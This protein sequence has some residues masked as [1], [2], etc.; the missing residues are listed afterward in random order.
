M[1]PAAGGRAATSS[2]RA[3][4]AESTAAAFAAELP[5][6]QLAVTQVATQNP[7]Q[8]AIVQAA[9]IRELLED[10]H[11]GGL[12]G[13][14]AQLILERCIRS[15]TGWYADADPTVMVGVLTGAL[16][17]SDPVDAERPPA[18]RRV[19]CA[20]ACLLIA[21][22]IDAAERADTD[23]PDTDR[24]DPDR[25]HTS[26]PDASQPNNHQRDSREGDARR[27]ALLEHYLRTA[28]A[29]IERAETIELP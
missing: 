13:A 24:S 11:P 28:L 2:I 29:E 8:L 5:R 23:R 1:S 6:F 3:A 22:L 16:G 15:A 21:D 18:D 26:R 17:L 7:E 14:D 9:I 4:I 19:L 27:S 20:H 10:L 12:S 25:P